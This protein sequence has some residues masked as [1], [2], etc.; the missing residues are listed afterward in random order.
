MSTQRLFQSALACCDW[1][2]VSNAMEILATLGFTDSRLLV[3]VV[4]S[5]VVTLELPPSPQALHWLW[6]ISAGGAAPWTEKV[7][8]TDEARR[9]D[10]LHLWLKRRLSDDVRCWDEIEAAWLDGDLPV[11]IQSNFHASVGLGAVLFLL[12]FECSRP[13]PDTCSGIVPELE[14]LIVG[15]ETALQHDHM[16][17]RQIRNLWT[18]VLLLLARCLW[19]RNSRPGR[20]PRDLAGNAGGWRGITMTWPTTRSVAVA[21]DECIEDLCFPELCFDEL[22]DEVLWLHTQHGTLGPTGFADIPPRIVQFDA[23]IGMHARA[24][25]GHWIE[26]NGNAWRASHMD[27][28]VEEHCGG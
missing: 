20:P 17:E 2:S 3:T 8:R 13:L 23:R 22:K 25:E 15:V 21:I 14:Q 10:Q 28:S 16:M 4:R 7:W 18:W 27:G 24:Y 6:D 11:P 26:H 5:L 1:L 19:I 9:L 12:A